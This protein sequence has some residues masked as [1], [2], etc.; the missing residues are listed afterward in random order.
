ML[1]IRAITRPGRIGGPRP[2]APRAPAH[3]VRPARTPIRSLRDK[4]TELPIDAFDVN[5]GLKSLGE[6][7]YG[8]VYEVRTGP[9]VW[10]AHGP[11]VGVCARGWG[12]PCAQR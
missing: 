4:G 9:R 10:A 1:P 2:I 11:R 12:E 3:Q 8:Q 7:S 5:K 6:G